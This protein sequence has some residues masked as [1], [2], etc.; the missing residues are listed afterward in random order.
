MRMR[1]KRNLDERMNYLDDCLLRKESSEFY[2]LDEKSKYDIVD[3]RDTFKRSAPLWL[4]LGCGKGKFTFETAKLNP[5]VNVIGV[6]KISNVILEPCERLKRER[7]GN[8]AFMNVGVENLRYYLPEN[9]VDRIFLNFSCPYP[10]YTYH[11]RRLTYYRYLDLYKHLL[12][13]GGEIW[14]KTDNAAFFEF[15]LQSFSENGFKLKNV[16]LDLHKSDFKGN[17]TTEYE[18]IFSAQGKPI[19]RVEA[20]L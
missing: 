4:E 10:K 20:Y 8:L 14:L 12:K 17:I 15:S 13:N 2:S 3:L 19:Y 1:R 5:D 6:E 7:I 18:E 11:N 16:C 9:C